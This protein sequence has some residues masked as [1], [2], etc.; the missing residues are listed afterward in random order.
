MPARC[1]AIGKRFVFASRWRQARPN[2][3]KLQ[4][5]LSENYF[6]IAHA[7]ETTGD[8]NGALNAVRKTLPITQK[9]ADATT[10]PERADHLAGS[11][12]FIAG[13]LLKTGDPAAAIDSYR[14]AAAVRD[15][16]LQANPSHTTLRTHLA[17]DYIGMASCMRLQGDVAQAMEMQAKA[18]DLLRGLS[19][20]SPTGVTLRE[21]LAEAILK[22]GVLQRDQGKLS[23]ALAS[24]R[25]AHNTFKALLAADANNS[26]ARAN[27]GFTDNAIA[28]ILV[29][30]GQPAAA[31]DILR[32]S[33]TTFRAMSP[34][35]ASNRY[36]RSG[37][38][39]A[40]STMG[41]AYAALA[42]SRHISR[43]EAAQNCGEAQSWYEKSLA[44]WIDKSRR[45][46]LESDERNDQQNVVNQIARCAAALHQNARSQH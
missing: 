31:M 26:L 4:T 38:A 29:Q 14:R 16:S 2:D 40:H 13:L 24:E 3:A 22:L 18:V 43:A 9:L 34:E 15:A 39:S 36:V 42:T 17:A 5:Q 20:P 35:T 30:S 23:E 8:L 10:D 27:F 37:F 7:L 44:L 1:R 33:L 21:Y 32:E 41:S 25:E 46:E 28:E 11:H 45:G 19:R 12:Y 6:R